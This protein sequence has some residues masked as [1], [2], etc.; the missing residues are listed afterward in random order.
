M[1][2]IPS[3]E[4]QLEHVPR[5][6]ARWPEI[7]EFALTFDGYKAFGAQLGALAEQHFKA[8][9]LPETLDELRG[10]LFLHQRSWR[11]VGGS[12]DL[13]ALAYFHRILEAIRAHLTTRPSPRP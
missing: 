8:Q 12:P 3:A 7:A 2:P 11:H 6:G 1:K 10:V 5:P 13:R 4:L 9:T